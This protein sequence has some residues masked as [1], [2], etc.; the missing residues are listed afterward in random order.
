[1]II[2]SDGWDL[3]D[4]GLLEKSLALMRR[5]VRKILWLSPHAGKSGFSPET[6]CL[7]IA[8]RYVDAILPLEILYDMAVLRKHIRTNRRVF[9]G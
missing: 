4:L 9:S 5:T 1:V 3:G 7:R 2:I 6:A 8:T